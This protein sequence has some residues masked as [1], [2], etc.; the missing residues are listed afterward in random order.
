MRNERGVVVSWLVKMLIGLAIG[1]VIIFDA[2]SI[3]TN[4]F[5]LDS[6]ADEVANEIATKVAS[7]GTA[8]S[9]LSG[10]Q[11]C[12][13]RPSANPLCRELQERVKKHDAKIVKVSVDLKGNLKLRLK[14]T[15]DTLVVSR[16]GFI[17]DWGTA[18]AEGRASTDTQ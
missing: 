3:A 9:D 17:E 11:T 16:I 2:G 15:A 14:R 13:K 6:A 7:G 5:G 10:L 4:F 12:G 18:T 1:G 8:Q